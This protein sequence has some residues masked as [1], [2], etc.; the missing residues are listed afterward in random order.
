MK[1]DTVTY[2][3]MYFVHFYINTQINY[4]GNND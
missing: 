2:T 1:L 3:Q 4:F